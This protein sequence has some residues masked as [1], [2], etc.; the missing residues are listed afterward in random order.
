VVER[1][2]F[3]PNTSISRLREYA[4]ICARFYVGASDSGAPFVSVCWR[5]VAVEVWATIVESCVAHVVESQGSNGVA[6]PSTS[7]KTIDLGQLRNSAHSSPNN[8]T[9]YLTRASGYLPTHHNPIP[10]FSKTA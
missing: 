8:A 7:P 1:L 3:D 4:G 6:G 2:V 9:I 10:S 5:F